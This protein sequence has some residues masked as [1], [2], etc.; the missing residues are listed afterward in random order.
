MKLYPEIFDHSIKEFT[1]H[2]DLKENSRLIFSGRYGI[3]KTTFL[4]HYFHLPY[5]V[6][7]YNIIHLFPVNYSISTNEDISNF[8][9]HDIIYELLKKVVPQSDEISPTQIAT[10]WS[11]DN[12]FRI[13][14]SFLRYFPLVGKELDS[15]LK[16]LQ[17]FFEEFEEYKKSIEQ[18]NEKSKIL[19]FESILNEKEGSIYENNF[20]SKLI[21]K[22]LLQIKIGNDDVNSNQESI[23]EKE[24]VLILDDLDRIDPNHTFRLFNIFSAHL[25]ITQNKFG[26]DKVIFVCDVKNVKNI[27]QNR[28]GSN[29]DFNGYIDKFYSKKV[30]YYDNLKAISSIINK[31]LSTIKLDPNY[32][33]SKMYDNTSYK[34]NAIVIL[35]NLILNDGLSLRVL[36]KNTN[37]NFKILDRRFLMGNSKVDLRSLSLPVTLEYIKEIIGDWDTTI[38]AFKRCIDK[39]NN[40]DTDT[41][42]YNILGE[43]IIVVDYKNNQ[44]RTT[45]H[46][47]KYDPNSNLSIKYKISMN[48]GFYSSKYIEEI[49]SN[50]I[51]SKDNYLNIYSLLVKACEIIRE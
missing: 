25:D 35:D 33:M 22:Y 30:F 29:V 27:F 40:F 23:K 26:F 34:T 15:H 6:E 7:R 45:E 3:G 11:L 51:I 43:L 8:L 36:L 32:S 31:I 10:Q 18:E 38:D 21:K 50:D 20:Y 39:P 41:N 14:A 48:T 13:L 17:K 12:S 44:L 1:Q 47:Y 24:N 19:A 28:Y 5:I 4:D 16:E 49:P 37:D 42:Y 9:K 46:H 2:I